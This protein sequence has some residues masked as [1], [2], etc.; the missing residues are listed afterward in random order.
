MR[1]LA[2]GDIHGCFTALQTVAA[3]AKISPDDLLITLG[4]Y[5]DRGPDSRSVL[6]W[7]IKRH[8]AGK[9]VALRGNHELMMIEAIKQR[10]YLRV[11]REC[12][13]KETLESYAPVGRPGDLSDV[14]ARHW[15]FIEQ[16]TRPY[17]EID[18]HFFVHANA[19]HDIELHEQPDYE[20]YWEKFDIDF[21]R[22]HAS[23]KV[24]V[25]GHTPQRNGIP[26]NHG[27]AICLDTWVY[28]GYWLTC[29]DIQSGRYWQA[30]QS[31]ETRDGCI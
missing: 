15:Q 27:H 30:N 31:G 23:G 29:L 2:I 11:W 26:T 10:E 19:M 28:K 14:P 3:F 6:D 18:T 7:L 22:P 20:I 13:G 17:H 9:L 1:T 25:C 4:D 8:E 21:A 24:M 5:V 16:E 12:G